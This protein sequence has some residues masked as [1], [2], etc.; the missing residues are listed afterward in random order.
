VALYVCGPLVAGTKAHGP[1]AVGSFPQFHGAEVL[2][3]DRAALPCPSQ[4]VHFWPLCPLLDIS[5]PCILLE[6]V[7]TGA[8]VSLQFEVGQR[9]CDVL[10]SDAREV[11]GQIGCVLDLCNEYC[12]V[13]LRGGVYM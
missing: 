13:E 11:H 12:S 1:A 8:A 10:G 6:V 3:V 7:I 9:G 5:W 2:R 4:G